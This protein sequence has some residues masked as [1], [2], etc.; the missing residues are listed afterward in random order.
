MKGPTAR[1]KLTDRVSVTLQQETVFAGTIKTTYLSAGIGVP[2][3]LLHGAGEGAVGWYPVID[4]LSAHFR[5]IAPDI[6]GYGESDKPSAPYDHPYFSAWLVEF[7]GALH[8]QKINLVGTSQGGAI[9]IQFALDN[10]ERIDKLV[11]VD[12]AALGGNGIAI[13]ALV[14]LL[15]RNTFPSRAASH[16]LRRYCV[17]DQENIDEALA[18]YKNEVCRKAGGKRAFWQGRG[19]T[20]A[21]VPLEQLAQV[22]HETLIIWGKEDRFFPLSHAQAA[23]R[24]MAN[25]RL[26]VIPKASHVPY[27]DQSEEF[28]DELIRFLG[29]AE[30][31]DP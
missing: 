28:N 15:W 25:G 7:L 6:V 31:V 21:P 17:Y 16:W 14:G 1:Q 27:F 5:V 20:A 19:R 3:V 11:L 26:H 2:V 4:P 22:T 24:V 8:L 29:D 30:S 12:S 9:S 18:D 10:S 23:Q 13:G